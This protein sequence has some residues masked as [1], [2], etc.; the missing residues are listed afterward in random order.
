MN[1]EKLKREI[2]IVSR[3]LSRDKRGYDADGY[4]EQGLDCYGRSRELMEA[5]AKYNQMAF[6]SLSLENQELVLQ[7]DGIMRRCRQ[8]ALEWQ[9]LPQAIKEKA[10]FYENYNAHSDITKQAFLIGV[11]M[12]KEDEELTDHAF[13][14]LLEERKKFDPYYISGPGARRRGM[15]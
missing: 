11:W 13:H 1:V 14:L 3:A 4:N 8:K 10:V 7:A 15:H 9:S 6:D 2:K 5:N 12:S